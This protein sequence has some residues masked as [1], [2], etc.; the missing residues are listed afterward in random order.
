MLTPSTGV[1]PYELNL[2]FWSDGGSKQRF[3]VLPSGGRVT[4][5]AE[6]KWQ[7]P[8]G[9]V[10]FKH[11]TRSD[12]LGGPTLRV[13][14]RFLIREADGFRGFAYRWRP[15]GSDADLVTTGAT[16]ELPLA[17]AQTFG[18]VIPSAGQC[19]TCHRDNNLD[20]GHGVLG[21]EARQLARSMS[22][23]GQGP[24]DQIDAWR[25]WGLFDGPVT[26]S[27]A[28]HPALDDEAVPVGERARAWLD[29]NCAFCHQPLGPA[30]TPLDLRAATAFADMALCDATPI[31]GDMGLGPPDE[32]RLLA[33]GDPS[34]SVLHA[35]IATRADGAMPP[36]AS[37]LVDEPA[38]DLIARWISELA[39]CP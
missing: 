33:P 11:F 13:E 27:P 36:L 6:G 20:G 30:G 7:V 8:T 28:R 34:L 37:R 5:S 24:F 35:R 31:R 10:L 38:R 18:W 14:T 26:A 23:A 9:T 3:M 21:L 29:V 15:D 2:P 4:W 16:V 12:P 19:R 25:A 39:T 17:E 32:V 22:Y 1:L